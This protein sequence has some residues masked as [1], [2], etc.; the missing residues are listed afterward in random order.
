M[1]EG[2]VTAGSLNGGPYQRPRLL[3][4]QGSGVGLRFTAS[5]PQLT[6][7]RTTTL[8][9]NAIVHCHPLPR[10]YSLHETFPGR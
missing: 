2:G 5:T 7:W 8:M 10:S 6:A 1:H 9:H 4:V 3:S